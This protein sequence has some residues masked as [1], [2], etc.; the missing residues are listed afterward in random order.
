[1]I[2]YCQWKEKTSWKTHISRKRL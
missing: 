2:R 1:M